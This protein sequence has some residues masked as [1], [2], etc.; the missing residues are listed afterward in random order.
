MG[1]YDKA[2]ELEKQAQEYYRKLCDQCADNE[3]LRNILKILSG[4]HRHHERILNEM[5]DGACQEK[6][7]SDSYPRVVN[8][9]REI[10]RKKQDFQCDMDL[11]QLY[12]EGL[13]FTREKLNFYENALEQLT[14]EKDKNLLKQVIKEEQNQ[15]YVLED[16]LEMVRRPDTWVEN[17]EFYHFEDY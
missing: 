7:G 14:C 17:A 6:P 8:I 10:K 3:G 1:F 5:K 12:K 2:I 13:E 15:V 9:F 16:I 4:D 11:L